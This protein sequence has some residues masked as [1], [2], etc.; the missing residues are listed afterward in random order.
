MGWI[1][2]KKILKDLKKNVYVSIKAPPN[3]TFHLAK[4]M[5]FCS[6]Q[7]HSE[8]I[9]GYLGAA[10]LFGASQVHVSAYHLTLLPRAACVWGAGRRDYEE[11]GFLLHCEPQ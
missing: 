8:L 9:F 1:C 4:E 11:S 10:C 3:P 6:A 7:V 5:C 2:P